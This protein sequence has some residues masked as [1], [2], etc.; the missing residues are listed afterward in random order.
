MAKRS[1][2][3]NRWRKA[4]TAKDVAD[5]MQHYGVTADE[6]HAYAKKNAG[7]SRRHVVCPRCSKVIETE[8]NNW[9]GSATCP[10]CENDIVIQ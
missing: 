1:T 4:G 2:N 3:F 10:A 6:L 9:D 8:V 5:L 7:T